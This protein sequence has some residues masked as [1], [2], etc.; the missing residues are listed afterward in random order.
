MKRATEG[1][2]DFAKP[3]SGAGEAAGRLQDCARLLRERV[4]SLCS[5]GSEHTAADD[6]LL[7]NHSYIQFQI[8]ELK[9]GLPA[10]FLRALPLTNDKS[11]LRIY[12]LATDLVEDSGGYID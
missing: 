3:V 6:W 7:D 9:R 8:R 1:N 12:R 2:R 10:S 5:Q 11:Q 4:K